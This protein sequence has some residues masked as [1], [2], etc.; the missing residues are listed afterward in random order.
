VR[1]S[2]PVR[3]FLVHLVLTLGAAAVAAVL[4]VH[5]FHSYQHK[6]EDAV[7]T[8]PTERLSESFAAEAARSLLLRLENEPEVVERDKKLITD[9]LHAMLKEVRSIESVLILDPSLRIQYASEDS[10]L[11]LALTGPENRSFYA[12]ETTQRRQVPSATGGELTELMVPVYDRGATEPGARRRIGSLLVRYRTDPGLLARLP[13]LQAPSVMPRDFAVPVILFIAAIATGGILTAAL[14]GL[15]VR[16]LE[17]ALAAF[18]ERGFRGPID[19]ARFGL[20]GE[21]TTAVRAINE[22][23]GKLEALDE[24]GQERERLLATLGDSL[25]DGMVAV[26]SD[27]DPT[28]WNQAALRILVAEAAPEGL[29]SEESRHWEWERLKEMLGRHAGLTLPTS[30]EARL[31]TL[32]V[33]IKRHSGTRGMVQITRVPFQIRPGREALLLLIRDL[34]TLRKVETHLLEAGRFAVLAHLAGGL[35]H[36]IRN[37]LHSIGVNASVLEQ[38]L[39]LG[40]PATESSAHAMSESLRSIRE[41]TTRLTDLLNNYLGFLR[42]SPAEGLVD[43]RDLCRRVTQ[44]L[45]YSALKANVQIRLQGVEALPPVHG[46]SDRLQQA[47]LNLVLNAIQAMPQGGVV[48]LETSLDDGNVRLTVRDSGPGI[49]QEL[50]DRLFDTR[51]TTKPGGSGLGLPLVRMIAET[52]GGSVW[53][54]SVPGEGASFTIELPAEKDVED[55]S[56]AGRA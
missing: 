52:H 21:L 49:P 53:C 1:L 20:D 31:E 6:W 46:V 30:G 17:R 56:R 35:A 22:M 13:Q 45:S 55:V 9:G 4:V 28:A 27:G 10:V 3:I 14:T 12:S 51:V 42:S 47:I 33:E 34:S 50:A 24:R 36:E 38:Y 40:L 16:K 39:A 15:P 44:L 11:D 26:D 41:E 25:E 7:A 18:R 37:P 2:L 8:L 32:E 54:R 19:P 23:G 43:I 29:G 5:A 48:V